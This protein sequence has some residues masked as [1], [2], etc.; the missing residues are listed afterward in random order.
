MSTQ[1]DFNLGPYGIYQSHCFTN[2]NYWKDGDAGNPIY[3]SLSIDLRHDRDD[4]L[5]NGKD[6][7]W[8]NAANNP[9]L[10]G[11]KL[12]IPFGN[13]SVYIQGFEIP[14]PQNQIYFYSATNT[15]W[16]WNHDTGNFE[17]Q[18]VYSTGKGVFG[19]P[20]YGPPVVSAYNNLA[21]TIATKVKS[22]VQAKN[23]VKTKYENHL[24]NIYKT[25]SLPQF[26]IS[27]DNTDGNSS[28]E[29]S[30]GCI[31]GSSGNVVSNT[32][33]RILI[34]NQD[35]YYQTYLY[36]KSIGI[37]INTGRDRAI[38]NGEYTTITADWQDA[39]SG[40]YYNWPTV[41]DDWKLPYD[42][43]SNL[44]QNMQTC[45]QNHYDKT[46]WVGTI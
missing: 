22:L 46:P 17:S 23:N 37:G 5:F 3:F 29:E 38:Q 45:L 4:S 9:N 41:R 10:W 19:H 32:S 35:T 1:L 26:Y 25:Y 7:D 28:M 42:F 34:N 2:Q 14:W 31:W 15:Y 43:P 16:N 40:L 24:T 13:Q 20:V 21:H 30:Q 6:Y 39:N 36:A 44:E 12:G 8:D 18:P 11:Q 33:N 27:F